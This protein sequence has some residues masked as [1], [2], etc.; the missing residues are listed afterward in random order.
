MPTGS[1][2]SVNPYGF[3]AISALIGLFCDELLCWRERRAERKA[4]TADRWQSLL[5]GHE[6]KKRS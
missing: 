2:A 6:K 5:P 3:I 1:L 4:E